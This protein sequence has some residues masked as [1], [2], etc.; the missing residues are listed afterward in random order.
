M[1]NDKTAKMAI[2]TIR[3]SY[4]DEKKCYACAIFDA[5]Q[6]MNG[7]F[8]YSD[9]YDTVG[10]FEGGQKPAKK[11]PKFDAKLRGS[12]LFWSYMNKILKREADKAGL[13]TAGLDKIKCYPNGSLCNP[14]PTI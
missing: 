14:F 12:L 8:R 10:T 11:P 4:C 13:F 5:R 9:G 1:I 3:R 2:N 6:Q 7:G